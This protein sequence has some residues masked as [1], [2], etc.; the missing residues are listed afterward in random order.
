MS[1]IN[2]E[3]KD[4]VSSYIIDF[5][6]NK[7]LNLFG[8]IFLTPILFLLVIVGFSIFISWCFVYYLF[9]LLDFLFLIKK[10]Q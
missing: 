4:L 9:I 6:N 8:K 3:F 5:Y 10:K 2:K 7:I 1:D